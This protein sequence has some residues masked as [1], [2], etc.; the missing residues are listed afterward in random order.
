M[1][2]KNKKLFEERVNFNYSSS[3]FLLLP[4]LFAFFFLLFPAIFIS[5]L[6]V[7]RNS[8]LNINQK[9]LSPVFIFYSLFSRPFTSHHTLTYCQLKSEISSDRMRHGF[10][11]SF[12]QSSS[13]SSSS[14]SFSSLTIPIAPPRDRFP[15]P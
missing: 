11:G 5:P 4:F 7:Y 1:T 3:L 8:S 6:F 13:S 2:P 10:S 15:F 14:S 9:E 12:H